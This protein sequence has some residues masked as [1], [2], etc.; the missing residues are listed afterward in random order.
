[1]R[2]CSDAAWSPARP[3]REDRRHGSRSVSERVASRFPGSEG[4]VLWRRRQALLASAGN[5]PRRVA[6]EREKALLVAEDPP[7]SLTAQLDAEPMRLVLEYAAQ[8]L[9]LDDG[10]QEL[11]LWLSN[12]RLRESATGRRRIRNAELEVLAAR[13]APPHGDR[14]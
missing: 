1:M 4:A 6:D 13:P 2:L 10:E 5:K 8:R 14:S 7:D 12:G 9:G 3:L 11:V